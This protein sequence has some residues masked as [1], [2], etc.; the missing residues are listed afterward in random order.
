M[1]KLLI[2]AAA[3]SL[4][5]SCNNSLGPEYKVAPVI[6]D[7]TYAPHEVHQGEVV[8]VKA[9]VTSQYGFYSIGVNYAINDKP[10]TSDELQKL[11]WWGTKLDLSKNFETKLNAGKEGDIVKFQVYAIS[12]YDVMAFGEIYE[13]KVLG[14]LVPTPDPDQG[15]G[16]DEI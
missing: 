14:K 8:T 15:D 12:A 7:V 10:A 2:F 1:K 11:V 3:I 16:E 13:Y 4:L 9:K 6:S 5:A